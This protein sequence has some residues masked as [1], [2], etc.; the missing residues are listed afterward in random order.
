MIDMGIPMV[1]D[2]VADIGNGKCKVGCK[3]K[4]RYVSLR[5]DDING[6]WDMTDRI[7]YKG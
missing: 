4:V 5:V 6:Y 3:S 7:I 2:D 1:V